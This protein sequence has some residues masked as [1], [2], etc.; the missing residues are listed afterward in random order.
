MSEWIEMHQL[1]WAHRRFRDGRLFG[2]SRIDQLYVSMSLV[3][4]SLFVGSAAVVGDV[5]DRS[6]PSGH[7]PVVARLA[8]ARHLRILHPL[9]GRIFEES[10]YSDALAMRCKVMRCSTVSEAQEQLCA[11]K[12]CVRGSLRPTVLQGCRRR[13]TR[14]G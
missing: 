13:A 14:H 11:L 2:A 7:L 3:A 9:D 10:G 4:C 8:L 6:F 12:K 5:F 1:G